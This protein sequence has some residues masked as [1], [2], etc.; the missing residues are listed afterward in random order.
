MFGFMFGVLGS[1]MFWV[2][3]FV[4]SIVAGSLSIK[5]F[6]PNTF[7]FI[8]TGDNSNLRTKK[9]RKCWKPDMTML[10]VIHM[11]FWPVIIIGMILF[12]I[13]KVVF[14]QMAWPLIRKSIVAVTDAVPE[15]EIT[16]NKDKKEEAE[17]V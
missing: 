1:V 15:V 4:L 11:L 6:A 9:G 2:V 5:H 13:I 17:D 14:A 3:Y 10:A 12:F 8:T 7:K 16:F